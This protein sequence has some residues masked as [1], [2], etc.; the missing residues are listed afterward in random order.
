[1]NWMYYIVIMK[2]ISRPKDQIGRLLREVGEVFSVAD[3]ANVL[4]LS[5]LEASKV[6]SRWVTQGW[7]TRPRRGFYLIVPLDAIDNQQAFEEPWLLA[8][9]LYSPCYVGGWS[10]T[11]YWDFTEQIFND[12]CILTE[13]VVLQKKQ[14]IHHSTFLLT[15]IP[16]KLNFGTRTIWKKNKKVAI[17]D[18]HKTI[19]DMFYDPMLGGGMQHTIDCFKIYLNSAH[20]SSEHVI[21]YALKINIGAVFKRLGYLYS[22]IT[23]KNDDITQLCQ[24][25]ITRGIIDID[26]FIKEGRIN[27]FWGLRVPEQI[28]L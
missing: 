2:N 10:A 9:M 28:Q 5:N 25:H 12:I 7:L 14:E 21:D 27:T 11:E 22:T 13:Q 3:A 26:P 15:H 19:I 20:F 1:M 24:K 4:A 17:S 16:K 18:P 8:S 6:L 23:G